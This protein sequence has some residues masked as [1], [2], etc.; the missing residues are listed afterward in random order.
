VL[1][2]RD[3]LGKGILKLYIKTSDGGSGK[4]Y[5]DFRENVIELFR[6][7]RMARSELC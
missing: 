5:A 4:E 2:S 1:T 7:L 6:A 3:L